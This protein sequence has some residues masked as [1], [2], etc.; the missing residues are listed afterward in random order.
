MV[1]ALYS[2]STGM[3]PLLPENSFAGVSSWMVFGTV[4]CVVA[5]VLVVLQ[6]TL[7]TLGKDK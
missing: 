2:E 5:M 1:L 3:G 4:C 6:K 7:G